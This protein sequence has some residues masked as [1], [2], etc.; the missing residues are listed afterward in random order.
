MAAFHA[1]P[2]DARAHFLEGS[3][4]RTPPRHLTDSF[5]IGGV[6]KSFRKAAEGDYDGPTLGLLLE[7]CAPHVAT[8][9]AQFGSLC[10]Q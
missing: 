2:L 9:S 10:C 8:P 4:L 1:T 7:A 3:E 5:P 6:R